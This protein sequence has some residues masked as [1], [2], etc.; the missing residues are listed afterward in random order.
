MARAYIKREEFLKAAKDGKVPEN[1]ILRKQFVCEKAPEPDQST[2]YRQFIVSTA[3]VDRDNDSISPKGWHLDNY[4]KNPVVLFAHDYTSLPIGKCSNIKMVGG[5]LIATAEFADHDMANTVM[6]L[7]DGGFLN[8]TS[9]GFRPMKYQLNDE[10]KGVDFEEQELLEFSIVPVPANPEALIV[11]RELAGD[12]ESLKSWAKSTLDAL[13]AFPPP[14]PE[15]EEEEEDD[16]EEFV[17]EDEE[18]EKGK[19]KGKKPYK[20]EEEEGDEPVVPPPDN[21]EEDIDEE[22]EPHVYPKAADIAVMVAKVL[23]AGCECVLDK[24]HDPETCGC[25]KG[26][27]CG[28]MCCS[29]ATK[30]LKRGRMLSA[31]N[32]SKI[33]A[34]YG[35]LKDVLDALPEELAEQIEHDLGIKDT[36]SVDVDLDLDVDDDEIDVDADTMKSALKDV[37]GDSIRHAVRDTVETEVKAALNRARGR[38]D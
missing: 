26:G 24:G 4:R 11:A 33:R 34:A 18:E 35:H 3:A 16:E 9:V 6:R 38:L 17:D 37:L 12:I 19:G 28:G 1:S 32:E 20:N 27:D 10:R 13:K 5:Q 29:K 30:A 21:D 36:K 8:A 31:K 22:Q 14:A 15:D 7:V 25:C 2:R 23:K